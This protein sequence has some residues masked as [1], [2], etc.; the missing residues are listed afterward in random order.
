MSFDI[1]G[2]Y[3]Y[4]S[5]TISFPGGAVVKNHFASAGDAKDACLI[6]GGED[7]WRRKWQSTP[8][9]LP[10][11]FHGQ[12]NLVGYSPYG[13][14]WSD[15]TEGL[16]C[17][18]DFLEIIPESLSNVLMRIGFHLCDRNA[19]LSHREVALP[20]LPEFLDSAI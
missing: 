20:F 4:S 17:P 10:G 19:L 6:S 8:V 2:P 11:K 12:R 15:T 14:I 13:W 18:I 9:F 3:N 1:P 7:P 16:T 5:C